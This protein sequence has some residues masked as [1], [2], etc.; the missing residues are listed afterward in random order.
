MIKRLVF[1]F[2]IFHYSFLIVFPQD[3]NK[4]FEY[5][6]AGQYDKAAVEFEN[7]LP[8]IEE[9]YGSTDTTYYSNYLVFTAY[10]YEKCQ[11][12][13]K[14]ETYYLKAKAIYEEND[15]I[16]CP[17]FSSILI[18]LGQ[19]YEDQ[20]N[21][22][23]TEPIYLQLLKIVK[24]TLGDDHPNYA[25]TLAKICSIYNGMGDHSKAE[26]FCI[27]VLETDKKLFGEISKEYAIDL[28]NLAITYEVKKDY[29]NAEL[30]YKKELH[31]WKYLE[32][33][34]YQYYYIRTL[35]HLAKLYHYLTK[36]YGQGESFYLQIL[37][38]LKKNKGENDEGCKTIITELA[39]LYQEMCDYEKAETLYLR[40]LEI[41]R[42]I[43]GE[44]HPD[45]ARSLNNLAIL[46]REIGNYEKAETLFLQT[47]EIRKKVLGEELP[48]YATSLNN[49]AHLYFDMGNYEKAETYFLRV[50]CFSV[51]T[52]DKS[53]DYAII[54]NNLGQLYNEIN[55]Y[56]KAE[57]YLLK[58]SRVFINLHDMDSVNYANNLTNLA[59]LYWKLC[60]YEAAELLFIQALEIRKKVLGEE[61]PD[62]AVSLN[63]VAIIY[64]DMGRYEKAE[65]F[66]IQ[67]LEITKIVFGVE[68][69]N[70]ANS[71]NNLAVTYNDVFNYEKAE[72][73]YL[74]ALEIRRKVLGDKH[75]AYA[76]SLNNLAFFYY[77]IGNYEKAEPLYLKSLEIKKKVFGEGH[78]YD[79]PT[80]ENLALLYVNIG[81]KEKAE[82]LLIE[83]TKIKRSQ[84][85]QQLSFLSETEMTKYLKKVLDSFEIFQGFSL[86]R[87][88]D[89]PSIACESY[90]VELTTKGLLLHSGVQMRK[91]ILS[92]VDTTVIRI[93]NDWVTLKA[94]LAKQYTLPISQR[95]LD[96]KAIE[97]EA[98][99]L[100]KQLTRSSQTFAQGQQQLK[101][102]WNDVQ[103][104]LK[105]DEVAIEFSSFNYHDG[106]R[107]TDST[108]YVALVLRKNDEYPKMIYLC[109]EKQLDSLLN[110]AT[111]SYAQKTEQLYSTRGVIING[112]TQPQQLASELYDL[113]WRPIDS[114][115]NGISTVY[116][117]PSGLLHKIS[118]AA[119]TALDSM[120]LLDKYKLVQLGSTAEIVWS[121][122]KEQYISVSDTAF[123]C[124]GINY[125]KMKKEK[126]TEEENEL[127]VYNR[128]PQISKDSTRS[129]SWRYLPGTLKEA[130]YIDSLFRKNKISTALYSDSNA[131][132]TMFKNL[133][134]QG[135]QIIHLS[136]HGFFFPEPKKEKP[137]DAFIRMGEET[138]RYSE[139][140]LL[141]S[142]LILAGANYVWKGGEQTPGQ[143]DG[144]LTAYEV[145]N[146]NLYNTKLVVMSACET[147][148]GDIKGSEGVFGL[149]RAFKMAGVDYIIMSL[150]KVP[151]KET[152][153]FMKLLY[154]N[155]LSNHS[156]REAFYLT[157]TT[158]RKKYNPYYWAAFVLVE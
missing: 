99:T 107:W 115:L 129:I 6:D 70:Y 76:N 157:Q 52:N 84:V 118:F 65:S 59:N 126:D 103:E 55:N 49:L 105:G 40:A 82:P 74:Q 46:Y 124:G 111:G 154:S 28:N 119:I 27:Q 83:V 145:S 136:T 117:S 147:G 37:Q 143:D 66:L 100:E 151:D 42:K 116:Y 26:T 61:H 7:A 127:F 12:Y 11:Q 79:D 87:K 135:S 18:S 132:E 158:M 146:M 139:N 33:D 51:D 94:S 14:A 54:L 141:R 60:N 62:Y 21:Y 17:L 134:G 10:S 123:I 58:A 41:N 122:N 156:I 109:E 53:N 144:I 137:K 155:C 142:G 15:A 13:F 125:D 149:Q 35:H 22:E 92:L 3:I 90:N 102:Q 85:E 108:Y 128:G 138:Y 5:Y 34:K 120:C 73:L 89:N 39:H 48:E 131:T 91:K 38:V 68:H 19:L 31:I 130:K 29:V 24:K 112:T 95:T 71:L 30:Y 148:L 25:W 1:L 69:P 4:A 81:E 67:A 36:D 106:K 152:T 150:W 140:P 2:I 110:Q 63:N 16:Y 101:T 75:P 47:L 23:K 93:Y 113:I 8:T 97:E 78:S 64:R 56:E 57:F 20:L 45:Y 114:L 86:K 98:N 88:I 72:P 77:N 153:E 104:K 50:L 43:L 133:S 32:S 9:K 121:E 96:V 80:L 44:E